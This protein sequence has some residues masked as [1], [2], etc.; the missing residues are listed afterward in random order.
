MS[1]ILNFVLFPLFCFS[2]SCTAE[3]ADD[4]ENADGDEADAEAQQATNDD[5]DI[6]NMV[7]DDEMEAAALKIQAQFRGFQTRKTVKEGETSSNDEL[8]ETEVEEQPAVSSSQSKEIDDEIANMVLDDE[9]ESAALKIQSAF[10]G[11]S[12]RKEVKE[13]QTTEEEKKDEE[14]EEKPAE[15][16]EKKEEEEKQDE[17]AAA[18]EKTAKQL[19]EEADIADLAMDEEMEQTALKIQSGKFSLQLTSLSI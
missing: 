4:P 16:E 11:K 1:T 10:R 17:A 8:K 5:D 7:L 19:Q 6:A 9:M 2:F 14:E 12:I 15:E 13:E 3:T 18:P